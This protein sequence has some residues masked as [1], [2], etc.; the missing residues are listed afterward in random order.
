MAIRTIDLGFTLDGSAAHAREPQATAAPAAPAGVTAEQLTAVLRWRA[1]WLRRTLST[2]DHQAARLVPALLQ[3]SFP[4]GD[5]R[6]EPPGIEGLAVRRTWGGLARVFD[7]PPPIARQRGKRLVAA[8]MATQGQKG[9]LEV[10]VIT[11]PGIGVAERARVEQRVIVIEDLM[12]TRNVPFQFAVLTWEKLELFAEPLLRLIPFGALLAGK[13]PESFWEVPAGKYISAEAMSRLVERAPT[14]LCA[15]AALLMVAGQALPPTAAMRKGLEE[16]RRALDLMDP[17]YFCAYWASLGG[18]PKRLLLQTVAMCNDDVRVRQLASANMGRTGDRIAPGEVAKLGRTLTL[19]SVSALRRSPGPVRLRL[20]PW[21]KREVLSRG[22]PAPLLSA[23]ARGF[24]AVESNRRGP[25]LFVKRRSRRV[26]EA[27]DPSGA[28]LGR[29]ATPEQ[30]QLRAIVLLARALGEVPELEDRAWKALGDRL[31]KGTEKRTLLLAVEGAPAMGSP[32]DPLNRGPDRAFGFGDML[33]VTLRPGGRP[34]ARR[35]TPLK[36]V[37]TLV[38]E[39]SRGTLVDAV[40][41]SGDATPATARLIRVANLARTT[42][43]TAPLALEAGGQVLLLGPER[44]R[45]YP[46]R[47]FAARP[48][49]CAPDPEAPDLSPWAEDKITQS[50]FGGNQ[51]IITCHVSRIGDEQAAILYLDPQGYQLHEEVPLLGLEGYLNDAQN[52][53]RARPSPMLLMIRYSKEIEAAVGRYGLTG[54]EAK[55]PFEVGGQ[56]PF[57]LQVT[58]GGETFGTGAQLGWEAA[59]QSVLSAMPSGA[60]GLLCCKGVN[61]DIWGR[62]AVGLARLYARWTAW[63]RLKLH[64]GRA[65]RA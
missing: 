64:V 4:T 10:F 26:F 23:L 49:R 6:G 42:N 22:M 63:R 37:E 12:H 51:L 20:R 54:T 60:H 25:P 21:V 53:L 58:M 17:E 24:R 65:C 33:V 30:A 61:V 11:A 47:S 59:A 46:L 40:A 62:P 43:V 9:G 56:L 27:C 52:I 13:L 57:G 2:R 36:A 44:V 31:A 5:L 16:G 41:V 32:H 35:L 15:H 7:L 18:D 39:A 38:T 1:R 28:P 29:G 3:A 45:R 19:A 50:P 48:R 14:P 34:C 55:V 8:V